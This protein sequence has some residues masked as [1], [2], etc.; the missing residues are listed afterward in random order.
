M[1][2]RARAIVLLFVGLLWLSA[3][4]LILATVMEFILRARVA[5]EDSPPSDPT[6]RE[7]EAAY[8]PF[9][10]QHLHPS[11]LFW[12]PLDPAERSAL[13][14]K[15][16]SLS[17]D[18]FRGPGPMDK[19]T[20]QLAFILG[21]SAAFGHFA[22]GNETTITGYLNALQD[23][24]LFVNAGVPSWISSQELVRLALELVAHKPALVIAYDGFN[25]AA[26]VADYARRGLEMPPSAPESFDELSNLVGDI[27]GER[28]SAPQ[29]RLHRRLFPRLMYE[30]DT[31]RAGPQ[32]VAEVKSPQ[33]SDA[34]AGVLRRGAAT[35]AQNVSSMSRLMKA[36]EA[37]FIG[38][39]QPVL[40]LH[41]HRPVGSACD[42]DAFQAE[43]EV[44]HQTVLEILPRD[45]SIRLCEDVR[46]P[47]QLRSPVLCAEGR[48]SG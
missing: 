18:G 14:N 15:V 48:S 7:L 20:R 6:Y 16:S 32:P 36:G 30:V 3:G 8:Q 40:S 24:Y 45:I 29:E 35:Y 4:G 41:A 33:V 23:Q 47:L 2:R 26:T 46:S 11:F 17:S 25:D 13:N 12:F 21:G 28:R 1:A 27:R 34:M 10:I 31:W 37:R 22:T 39:F 19:G 9:T 44:F 5:A 43:I 42:R 38:V